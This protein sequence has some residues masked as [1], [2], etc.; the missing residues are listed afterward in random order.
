MWIENAFKF[1]GKL[2]HFYKERISFLFYFEDG[3]R[4]AVS[5][6]SLKTSDSPTFSMKVNWQPHVFNESQLTAPRFQWKS[7]DIGFTIINDTLLR[8]LYAYMYVLKCARIINL[9]PHWY[10][11]GS[12]KNW[13][14]SKLNETTVN[15]S[16]DDILIE[17]L[18]NISTETITS[19]VVCHSPVRRC[20]CHSPV[21]RCSCHSPVRRCSCHS[22]VRRCSCHSSVRRC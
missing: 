16:H 9:F 17:Y 5:W 2:I 14:L 10:E 15:K 1:C 19:F 6:L 12:L 18:K 20:S 4:G 7:T 11:N 22:S 8:T 3:K 13:Y 21:R